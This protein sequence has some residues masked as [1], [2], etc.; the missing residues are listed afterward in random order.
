MPRR[1]NPSG[2][3]LC[4]RE[5]LTDKPG[6]RR[7]IGA[8]VDGCY[9]VDRDI[10]CLAVFVLE[11]KN[12]IL[13][14]NDLT[15]EHCS[16]ATADINFPSFKTLDQFFHRVADRSESGVTGV[17]II[18]PFHLRQTANRLTSSGH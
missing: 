17:K 3:F 5:S 10:R 11:M 14:L 2:A 13:D 4:D 18:L 15:P 7:G 8:L 6:T 1:D 12:T 9:L 16:R